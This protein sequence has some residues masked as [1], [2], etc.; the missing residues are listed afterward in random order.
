MYTQPRH[1]LI[2]LILGTC[3][4]S[5]WLSAVVIGMQSSAPAG[6]PTFELPPVLVVARKAAAP[7][8]TPQPQAAPVKIS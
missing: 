8:T 1:T 7:Q 2:A 6:I 3:I 4:S 5:A